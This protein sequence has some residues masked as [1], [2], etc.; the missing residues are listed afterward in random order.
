VS[1][2]GVPKRS[3]DDTPVS[4]TNVT[5]ERGATNESAEESRMESSGAG[6]PPGRESLD[7]LRISTDTYP[8][9]LGGGA[10]HAHEMSARQAELGHDVTVLTS[11][12][13]DRA[14][15]RRDHRD[16]YEVRR[17]R[18]LANPLGNSLTPGLFNAV[19]ERQADVDI[20]HAHSHLYLS[21]NVA[22]ALSALA[23]TPLVVTNH[24]LYS[25]S[26]P[27]W[28]NRAFLETVGR[29]TFEAAD[30]VLCYTD[31]D[32]RRLREF[33]ISAPVSVVHNGIDCETFEPVVDEASPHRMLFV[34][35]LKQ[36]KGVTRLL[37][38]FGRLETEAVTLD[39]VGEG[40]LRADLEDR[41]QT[42][43]VRD[44][45][46][47]HGRLP[48]DELPELYARSA[49]F[50]LP[51]TRE[52]LPRTVLEAMACGTPVVTSDIPQL[53]ALVDGVGETVPAADV[54]ALAAAVDDLLAD[55]SRRE[56]LG[57]KA[58]QR[59][60]EEYSWAETVRETTAVYYDLLA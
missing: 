28:F 16:G 59:V 43:G 8:E 52:G 55:P 30:R 39:I 47:F 29:L 2:E 34:G 49:V 57:Q 23:D 11:D 26:A 44:D 3:F 22:A 45:V 24:G 51:S 56:R 6:H 54:G 21:T 40:P 32:E 20:V 42:L 13:G 50:A 60:V 4:R 27:A 46:T 7:I 17:Y 41:A 15:P 36:S 1:I 10:L 37:D 5:N 19:R 31:T 53:Q 12:H 25:Q 18:E 33:G 48:N 38:A 14:L 35:R 9:V 58:R